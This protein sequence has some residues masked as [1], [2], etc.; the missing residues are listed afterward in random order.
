MKTKKTI[1]LLI[2][3]FSITFLFGFS[4]THLIYTTFIKKEPVVQEPYKP[5]LENETQPEPPAPKPTYLNNKVFS[6][7]TEQ[8]NG[9]VVQYK[10]TFHDNDIVNYKMDI[11]YNLVGKGNVFYLIYLTDGNFTV[12]SH[13]SGENL[14]RLFDITTFRKHRSLGGKTSS[15]IGETSASDIITVKNN[16]VWYLTI[17][18]ARSINESLSVAFETEKESMEINSIGR[19]D[20]V[21][22]VSAVDADYKDG[23]FFGRYKGYSIFGIGLSHCNIYKEIPVSNGG[24][25]CVDMFNYVDGEMEI[26]NSFGYRHQNFRPDNS[27]ILMSTTYINS[28]EYWFI[29]AQNYAVGKK[30]SVLAFVVDVNPYS[31]YAKNDWN[32][33]YTPTIGEKLD[34]SLKEIIQTYLEKYL[35]Q[36]RW[37]RE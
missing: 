31:C 22:L 24:I 32:G 10:I 26:G 29:T 15:S 16:T 28:V 33:T 7:S 20:A 14:G 19:T 18:V 8:L 34:G 3:V 1:V 17:A 25:M 35:D 27:S 9:E 2:I 13:L 4:T 23:K 12:T 36:L 5:P 6:Q 21:T 11:S 30:S 37:E